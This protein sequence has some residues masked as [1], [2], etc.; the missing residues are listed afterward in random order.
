VRTKFYKIT[1]L[2]KIYL[3]TCY[4]YLLLYPTQ[5]QLFNLGPDTVKLFNLA[6]QKVGD[7]AC[8]I[9]LAPLIL[10]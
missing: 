1:I 4:L 5:A 2:C 10:A 6:A 3:S 9:I 7:L 8:K